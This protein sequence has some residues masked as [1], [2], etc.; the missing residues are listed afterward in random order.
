MRILTGTLIEHLLS[1]RHRTPPFTCSISVKATRGG[2]ACLSPLFTDD[3]TEAQKAESNLSKAAQIQTQAV[4]GI[5][6]PEEI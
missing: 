6:R 2:G 1:A 3:E 5:G 4:L